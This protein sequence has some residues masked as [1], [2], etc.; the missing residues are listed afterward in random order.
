VGTGPRAVRAILSKAGAI[1]VIFITGTPGDCK[2]GDPPGVI[3]SKPIQRRLVVDT[4]R[5]LVAQ[6]A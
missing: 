2:P 6:S 3:L 1:P 4:F 5:Q